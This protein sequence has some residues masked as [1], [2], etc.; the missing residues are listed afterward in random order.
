M[1]I[2]K[3][4]PVQAYPMVINCGS[5]LKSFNLELLSEFCLQRAPRLCK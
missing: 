1:E 2:N 5:G 4:F 3:R